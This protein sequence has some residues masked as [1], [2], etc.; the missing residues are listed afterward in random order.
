MIALQRQTRASSGSWAGP[1]VVDA[2]GRMLG[3]RPASV[4]LERT[5]FP[6]KR[7][8]QLVLNAILPD[9]RSRPVLA[10]R[11]AEDSEAEAERIRASL[12]KSRMGQKAGYDLSAVMAVAAAGLVLRK[13]GLDERLPG[14]RLLHDGSFAR[15]AVMGIRGRDAGPVRSELVAHRLGKRAVVRLRDEVGEIY[16]RLRAIKSDDGHAR[17]ARHRGLWS[18]LADCT[19]LTIPEPLGTLPE[20][21]A[22]FY[23]ALPGKAPD[24]GPDESRAIARAIAALQALDPAGLP[25][26]SGADEARLLLEWLARCREDRPDIARRISPALSGIL[27]RLEGSDAPPRCCHRDLHE[28]QILIAGGVAGLLD[29][30]TLCLSH[31]ALDPGNLLAH[32]F[33]ARVDEAPLW[34]RLERPG[35]GLWRSAALLRLAMI[36]AFTST[37]EDDL[38]RLIEEAETN[39]RY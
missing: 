2:I 33:F 36:Y 28:K 6:G 25:L 18:R 20:I 17:L 11:Y 34:E 7:P 5:H 16:V 37:P 3:E 1:D 19:D 27:P 14:L 22:S 32:L 13:P 38:H 26:H 29:F 24:F 9:G 15:W 31:P 8:V 39:V 10:E 4:T 21:G 30:D 23:G 12:C 35:L